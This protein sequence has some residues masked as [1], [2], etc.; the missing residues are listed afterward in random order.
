MAWQP[1]LTHSLKGYFRHYDSDAPGRCVHWRRRPR[2]AKAFR[3][4]TEVSE[5]MVPSP[6]LVIQFD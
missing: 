3:I 4:R 6:Q 5:R 1:V 2:S